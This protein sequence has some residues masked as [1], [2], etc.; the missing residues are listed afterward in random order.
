MS[1]SVIRNKKRNKNTRNKTK[2]ETRQKRVKKR[3]KRKELWVW[4]R[5][6]NEVNS[7]GRR[8]TRFLPLEKN[9]CVHLYFLGS[10]CSNGFRTL[11][12]YRK[13]RN[14]FNGGLKAI[15]YLLT[16]CFKIATLFQRIQ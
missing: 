4:L 12:R 13:Q 10:V 16:S 5:T 9:G 11:Q 2:T 1:L 6:D 8:S 15:A 7:A 3:E 14:S